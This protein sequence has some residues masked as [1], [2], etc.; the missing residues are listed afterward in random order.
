[1]RCFR[2]SFAPSCLASFN[3]SCSFLACRASFF[4]WRSTLFRFAS[5]GRST[6]GGSTAPHRVND[7]PSLS[8]GCSSRSG[9]LTNARLC[10]TASRATSR[11]MRPPPRVALAPFNRVPSKPLPRKPLRPPF[12]DKPLEAAAA[13]P[14]PTAVVLPPPTTVLCFVRGV[15][16]SG[17][18]STF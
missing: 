16:A 10:G 13:A 8:I 4:S 9:W 11:A 14:A 3:F 12:P 7:P 18:P 15:L 17:I 2:F 1:M 5:P 6:V